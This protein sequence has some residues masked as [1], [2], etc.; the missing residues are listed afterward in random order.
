MFNIFIIITAGLA[1]GTLGGLLGIGGGIILMPLL[2]FYFGF[3]PAMAAGTCI[4]AVFFTTLGGSL[5]HYRAGNIKCKPLIPVII[6]GAVFTII[7]SSL[8]PQAAKRPSL[9][10]AGIGVVFFLVSMRMA[11]EGAADF[12]R[13]NP[14]A[15]GGELGGAAGIKITIGALAGVLPGM[16]GIGTGAILVPA[17][18][19]ILKA[20]VKAAIGSSLLCFAVNAF[21][22]SLFKVSQGFADVK[23][24]LLLSLG[25]LAGA[26]AGAM[27]NKKSPPAVLKLLFGALFFIIALKYVGIF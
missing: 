3:S 24:A 8:F 1:A 10:D 2:R 23:L 19:F 15:G 6:S 25:T 13:K 21:I 7:F 12:I 16:V 18:R 9:L 26:A 4:I 22:S 11:A 20:P 27:I 14:A 17:F 5:K